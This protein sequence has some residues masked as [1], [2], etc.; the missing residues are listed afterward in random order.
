MYLDKDAIL[1]S[2]TKD[3][4]TKIVTSLG[5]AEPKHDSHDNL[6]FQTICHNAPSSSNSYKLYYYHE[7]N[8]EHTGRVFHCYSGCGDSFSIVELVIR[9]NRAQGKSITWYKALYYIGSITGKLK[10]VN[11]LEKKNE[12]QHID[13]FEWINK[14]SQVMHKHSRPIPHLK[15][16][17]EHVLELFT[18]IPH[19][20]W[21]KAGIAPEALS[22]FEIGYYPLT[23]QIT[24]PHRDLNNNLIGV[25]GRNLS[26]EALEYAKYVPLQINGEY[27]SHQLG[28]CLYG[29]WVTQDKIK[30]CKK[31]LVVEAEK[32]AL[33]AYTYF[34]E[35]S[36]CVATC[37]SAI[38]LVQQKILLNEFGINEI[39]YAPDRD[40]HDP[41]SYE[42]QRWWN[43]QVKKVAPFVPY[44]EVYI[45]ADGE[46]RLD[47]KDSPLDKGKDI[48]LELYEN[49]IRVT[50]DDVK[51]LKE[52]KTEKG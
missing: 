13:D 1:N 45:V 40:Y 31:A 10:A 52:H 46:Y 34:G 23:D 50:L 18:Y 35:D 19:E 12:V 29:G 30:A 3:D 38:T 16:V 51:E 42:A 44:C 6:I 20:D 21:I 5:S 39:I 17:D 4:I 41:H 25:R 28:S 27:T 15:T 37:G 7:G 9:A 14:I 11:I 8:D 33:L 43:K 26:K 48:F 22:R 24:I 2:L 47:Y 32:S 36:Y 49:K